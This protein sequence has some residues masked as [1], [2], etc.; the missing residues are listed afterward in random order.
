[1]IYSH[2]KMGGAFVIIE[3]VIKYL[4]HA[5]T[6]IGLFATAVIAIGLAVTAVRYI[7]RLWKL[8]PKENFKK[9]RTELGHALTLGLEI[10]VLADVI[11]TITV[12]PTLK[13]LGIL[14]L[15]IAVRTA[16][17]WN[18]SLEIN[19]CWPWREPPPEE[20]YHD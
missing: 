10:L 5:S 3:P 17:S 8:K 1:M 16:V 4:E 13:S 20:Q 19:Q 7:C 11:E 14:A 12:E 15:L 18:F 2:K 6:A 9:F